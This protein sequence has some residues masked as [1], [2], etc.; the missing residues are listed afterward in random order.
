[1]KNQFNQEL[2]ASRV[3]AIVWPVPAKLWQV[4]YGYLSPPRK[5]GGDFFSATSIMRQELS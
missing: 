1:M 4:Q 2:V 5:E 3:F